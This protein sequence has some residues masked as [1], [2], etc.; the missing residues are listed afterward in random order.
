MPFS[1]TPL[2]LFLPSMPSEIES[3]KGYWY[4]QLYENEQKWE[5]KTPMETTN[6]KKLGVIQRRRK[7]GR[8]EPIKGSIFGVSVLGG[9]FFL[10]S[11]VLRRPHNR[12]PKTEPLKTNGM[13]K[14]KGNTKVK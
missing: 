14:L 10:T 12:I 11:D 8:G 1:Y 2:Q 4:T 7:Y 5:R 9:S 13:K 3:S 6:F